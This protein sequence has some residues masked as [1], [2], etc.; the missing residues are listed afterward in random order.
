M[1]DARAATQKARSPEQR[2]PPREKPSLRNRDPAKDD[3]PFAYA[4]EPLSRASLGRPA[5][6]P[7]HRSHMATIRESVGLCTFLG[8]VRRV[9]TTSSDGVL[10]VELEKPRRSPVCPAQWPTIQRMWLR[11]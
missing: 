7:P 4:S 10:V 8:T 1:S 5:A 3:P 11:H 9:T 6:P 2:A